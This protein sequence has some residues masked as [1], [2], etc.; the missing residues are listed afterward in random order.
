KREVCYLTCKEKDPPRD[1]G[2]APLSWDVLRHLGFYL[3]RCLTCRARIRFYE[4][5][6]TN[7]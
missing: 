5:R 6:A 4:S 2:E 3:N 7:T 1:L